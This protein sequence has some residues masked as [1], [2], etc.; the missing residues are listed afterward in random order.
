MR[1]FR[2]SESQ[3]YLIL[4]FDSMWRAHKTALTIQQIRARGYAVNSATLASLQQVGM[5]RY[6]EGQG[7]SVTAAGRIYAE[8]LQEFLSLR[9]DSEAEKI[10]RQ[11]NYDEDEDDV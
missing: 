6:I 8:L 5:L 1:R 11:I 3:R 4:V 2:L 7:W 10:L 9:R